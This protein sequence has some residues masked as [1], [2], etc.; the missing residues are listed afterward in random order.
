M[1]PLRVLVRIQSPIN[2]L[3]SSPTDHW[4]SNTLTLQTNPTQNR[5]PDGGSAQFVLPA[6]KRVT[7][8]RELSDAAIMSLRGVLIPHTAGAGNVV[9]EGGEACEQLVIVE[10]VLNLTLVQYVCRPWLPFKILS[11]WKGKPQCSRC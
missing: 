1:N 5:Q 6:L 3:T 7:W 4:Q 8:C 2:Q 9:I 10:K 11:K